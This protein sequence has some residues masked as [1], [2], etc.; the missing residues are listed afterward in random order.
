[1]LAGD[2]GDE[3]FGGNERY[4]TEKKYGLYDVL[5]RYVRR[6]MIEPLA[7]CLPSFGLT[8]KVRRYIGRLAKGNPERYFQW[9][10]LQAFPPQTVLDRAVCNSGV[11]GDL[12]AIPRAHYKN[13][14]AHSELNRLL[15]IDIKMTLGDNDLPKVVR[16]AELAGVNVRFPYLDHPLADFSGRLPVDLKVRGF[17]K[18]YLFKKAMAGLLPEAI[19]RKKKHGFGLPIGLWL[20]QHPLW[21]G[22]AEDILLEPRTYQRGYFQRSFVEDLFRKMDG[23]SSTYYGDLLWLFMM[24]ELWHRH[25]VESAAEKAAA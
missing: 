8:G 4:Q 7:A 15:Y 13:A 2:G 12:L 5:P 21:R 18:R 6:G 16:A 24:L 17:E 25:H 22:L 23:D 19:L 3:L 20:K 14:P 11:P 10:L 1:M 9:L